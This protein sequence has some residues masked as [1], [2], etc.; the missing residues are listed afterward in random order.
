MEEMASG[1]GTRRY[2][3][4]GGTSGGLGTFLVG[5]V[6]A[7]AGGYL[8]L[9]QVTVTSH[10]WRFFGFDAFGLSLVPLLL[11]VGLLF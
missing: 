4:V 11:G 5:L 3:N 1:G 2:S 7:A 9:Q 8:L 6:M 10:M